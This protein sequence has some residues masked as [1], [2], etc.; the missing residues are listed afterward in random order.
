MVLVYLPRLD[1]STPLLNYKA[2][3]CRMDTEA[4]LEH[5]RRLVQSRRTAERKQG[6][7]II[8]GMLSSDLCIAEDRRHLEQLHNIFLLKQHQ[9]AALGDKMRLKLRTPSVL[10][11][12]DPTSSGLNCGLLGCPPRRGCVVGHTSDDVPQGCRFDLSAMPGMSAVPIRCFV[13]RGRR[14]PGKI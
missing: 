4:M 3:S 5:V 10:V 1:R 6:A 2:S 12:I 7:D 8:R 9:Y 11:I 13:G 14:P